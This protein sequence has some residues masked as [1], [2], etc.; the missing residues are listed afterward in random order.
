VQVFLAQGCHLD[1]DGIDLRLPAIP[2]LLLADDGPLDDLIGNS[3]T[4]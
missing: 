3:L 2:A 4:K 1:A